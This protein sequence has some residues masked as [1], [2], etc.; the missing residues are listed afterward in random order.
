MPLPPLLRD[1]MLSKT[2]NAWSSAIAAFI[3]ICKI[4]LGV[5]VAAILCTAAW[6]TDY[7]LQGWAQLLLL[8]YFVPIWPHPAY[9]VVNLVIGSHVLDLERRRAPEELGKAR[10]AT[11][12]ELSRFAEP[13]RWKKWV[14]LL[15]W[16]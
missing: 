13:P 15:L 2:H 7:L 16:E 5:L 4:G 8:L 9:S 10:F 12:R 3:A 6:F 1:H 14:R 11:K